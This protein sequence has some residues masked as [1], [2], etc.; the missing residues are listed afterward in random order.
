MKKILYLLPATVATAL[1]LAFSGA[2]PK[3][4]TQLGE[5][6]FSDPILSLDS[7]VSCRSCHIPEFAFADT[8]RFSRGVGGRLGRRNAPSITNM[9][10]RSHFF[11]DGRVVALEDQVLM[12]IQD[13]VEMRLTLAQVEQR[14]R[15]HPVYGPAFEQI[16]GRKANAEDLAKALATFVFTLETA[17]TP[18]DR[19]MF[20]EPGGMSEA[21][22]R[23]RE[24]F[25]EKGKCFDCHFTAD[26][27]G[28]EF[29]NVGLYNGKD[30]NDAGRY[31][32][33]RN[34]ADLGKFKVPGLRNVALTAPYMHN[35]MFRSLDEV[36][37]FYN[38]PAK[39]MPD[40]INRDTS[41]ATPLNLTATEKAELKAFLEA[42][43]DDQFVRNDE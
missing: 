10:A 42:L 37:D 24:V 27:T 2:G 25:L 17:N 30:L 31:A 23:G 40:A 39:A 16:F 29:K 5:R 18:Y 32:I 33:T 21:A 38:D 26:F 15:S 22:V 19:W 43:T 11:F 1:L 28:D 14:L 41:L 13:T 12:P 4:A 8:A 34:P 7:T 9:S 36:I 6:L 35:G 3:D 20:D